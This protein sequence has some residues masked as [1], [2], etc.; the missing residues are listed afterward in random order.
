MRIASTVVSVVFLGAA[1][2]WVS[3]QKMP[4]FPSSATSYLE[5]VAALVLYAVATLC[6]GER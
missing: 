1:A 4:T 6:R 2:W 5:L 3:R